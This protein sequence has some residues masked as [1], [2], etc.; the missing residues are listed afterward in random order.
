[1]TAK[2]R[3]SRHCSFP[4]FSNLATSSFIPI[5]S[6]KETLTRFE[7]SYRPP[8]YP[9]APATSAS[10]QYVV[11]LYHHGVGRCPVELDN[12]H[13]LFH[14]FEKQLD[15][16]PVFI[17]KGHGRWRYVEIVGHEL[18]RF[19]L[20]LDVECHHAQIPRI[21]L[22]RPSACKPYWHVGHD[23]A[24]GGCAAADNRVHHVPFPP[25]YEKALCFL[26]GRHPQRLHISLVKH[27]KA[28]GRV[29]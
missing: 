6:V 29:G 28:I 1:M 20:V 18:H 27:V 23:G 26:Y 10:R 3:L 5:F 9:I 13:V 22:A 4:S 11:Y 7:K 12:P 19:V 25:Y 24:A 16:P 14:P 8:L 2:F 15:L 21:P 17:K